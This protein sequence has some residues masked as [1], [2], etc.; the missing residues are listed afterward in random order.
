MPRPGGVGPARQQDLSHERCDYLLVHV[1]PL[2]YVDHRALSAVLSEQ[3]NKL[4]NAGNRHEQSERLFAYLEWV[5]DAAIQL[6]SL[7]RPAS[8]S[9]LLYTRRYEHLLTAGPS[10]I[11]GSIWQQ[12]VLNGLINA[13]IS[14]RGAVFERA[15]Q[16]VDKRA[17]RWSAN[18]VFIV[19]DTNF[20]MQHE[21]IFDEVEFFELLAS[22]GRIAAGEQ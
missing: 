20:Y 14:D 4:Q 18:A 8:V 16:E 15:S 22:N 11:G 6:S 7:L 9:D 12:R 3:R 21:K 2:P 5:T 17:A 19:A 1:E 13:E 10:L